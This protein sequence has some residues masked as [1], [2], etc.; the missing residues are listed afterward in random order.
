MLERLIVENIPNNFHKLQKQN[1]T[2]PPEILVH[3]HLSTTP[4]NL[5]FN[6]FERALTVNAIWKET[7]NS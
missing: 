7:R 1:N 6:K 5:I 2:S 3:T 4:Q